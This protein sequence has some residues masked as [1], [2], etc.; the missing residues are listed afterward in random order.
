MINKDVRKSLE[1]KK[2]NDILIWS[3]NDSPIT[4][5]AALILGGNHLVLQDL[6]FQYCI[7]PIKIIEHRHG[8]SLVNRLYT[9]S[10]LFLFILLLVI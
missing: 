10:R 7:I 3:W 9:M 2:G 6:R 1:R 8:D 5:T 4:L